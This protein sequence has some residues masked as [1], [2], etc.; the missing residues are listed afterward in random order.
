MLGSVV[1]E[2][3][4][5]ERLRY[6]GHYEE[7]DVLYQK[8]L[9]LARKYLGPRHHIVVMHMANMVGMYRAHGDVQRG[10]PLLREMID[11]LRTSPPMRSLPVFVDGML[12]YGDFLRQRSSKEASAMYAEALQF[13]RERPKENEKTLQTL[14]QRLRELETNPM[15]PG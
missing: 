7:A 1:L 3:I 2:Y 15:P 5:A 6:T 9:T 14:E 12:Q 13:G 4:K 10:E 8:L 11:I